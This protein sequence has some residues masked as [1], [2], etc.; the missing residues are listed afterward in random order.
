MKEIGLSAGTIEYEDMGG[1]G[2]AILFLHGL[3]MDGTL[4]RHVVAGLR[5][6]YRCVLPTLP[7]GGHRR[8]M[9]PDA[10][11]SLP[12][13]AHLL[14]EFLERL[15]LSGVTLVGNDWGG[16][17]LLVPEGR[18]ERVGRLVLVACEAF[19]D[20]PPGGGARALALAAELPG[21]LTVML[22]PLRFGRLRRLP[23]LRGALSKRPVPDDVMDAWFRPAPTQ[24]EIRRD[25]RKYL[26]SVPPKATCS[27]GRSASAPSGP[28]ARR[29][30][31]RRPHHAVRARSQPGR[32]VPERAPRR[33]PGQ[34]HPHPRG[35]ARKAHRPDPRV[36]VHPT[37][38]GLMS[39]GSS[40]AITA[41]PIGTQQR[42]RLAAA[43]PRW[44]RRE[45]HWAFSDVPPAAVLRAADEVTW[46]EVPVFWGLMKTW[47]LGRVRLAAG[48][49]VLALFTTAGF[50][51]LDRTEDEIV[52]GGIGRFSRN[53]PLV[54]ISSL[55]LT[56]YRDFDEPG[57]IKICFNFRCTGGTL[58][59]ETRVHA[60]D[61][62]S[63]RLFGLYWLLIRGGSG[64]IRQVWPRAIRRRALRVGLLRREAT[65]PQKTQVQLAQPML[66]ETQ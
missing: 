31:A 3:I 56:S 19:D 12:A 65:C 11:L 32:A 66:E 9:R 24:P 59:T 63:R 53:R 33:D 43:L 52:V 44:D 7:L 49:P 51:V 38:R 29:L 27:S 30:G 50:A 55:D 26:R 6:E 1:S 58:T 41:A 21:G 17:Q 18:A 47:S 64:L 61:T 46:R 25:L 54:R 45:R 8:P 48:E 37:H 14:A 28:G 39:P 4:W 20:Y 60:T 35:P 16:A 40:S 57:C 5:P 13:M 15:D 62:R 2:P 23:M 10:D 34:L 22:Q 36:R 42:T